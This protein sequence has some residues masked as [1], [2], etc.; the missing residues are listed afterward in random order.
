MSQ[1]SF[2]FS[3]LPPEIRLAVWEH[4]WPDARVAEIA[5]REDTSDPELTLTHCMRMTGRLSTFLR[6]EFRDRIR[7]DP[8][9]EPCPD[10]VALRVCRESRAHAL[11]RYVPMRHS[12]LGCGSFYFHPGRDVFWLS[13]DYYD[14]SDTIADLRAFYS[15][16]WDKIGSVVAGE[17][18]WKQFSAMDYCEQVLAHVPGLRTF[19]VITD[20]EGFGEFD[21]IDCEGMDYAR[22]AKD[23]MEMDRDEV[24]D[25]PWRIRYMDREENILCEL[26]NDSAS[27]RR[28]S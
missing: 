5:L 1:N 18:E 11:E 14:P 7:E 6:Q 26:I 25:I 27:G 23:Q 13:V 20:S 10:P 21:G 19:T 16:D 28:P 24:G 15:G 17:L 22:F 4:T 12:K 8:P 9:L 3:R 2:P